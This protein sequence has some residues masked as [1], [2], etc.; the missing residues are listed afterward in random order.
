MSCLKSY[1]V[2]G[3]FEVTEI[4]LSTCKSVELKETSH[5]VSEVTQ[6]DLLTEVE[7]SEGSV[8]RGFQILVRVRTF[9]EA[10]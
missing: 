1:K 9:E 4:E 8:S 5:T 2:V 7:K 6:T 3:Y 10:R